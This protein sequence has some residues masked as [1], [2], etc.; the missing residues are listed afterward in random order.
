MGAKGKPR[1]QQTR[2][3][4]ILQPSVPHHQAP[5]RELGARSPAGHNSWRPRGPTDFDWMLLDAAD[6]AW[7]VVR[8]ETEAARPFLT[9]A[10][11]YD[12]L[13]Q[14]LDPEQ[15]LNLHDLLVRV[16]KQGRAVDL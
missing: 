4:T 9:P 10:E 7:E 14:R 3:R 12:R 15:V 11:Y 6:D 13:R 8:Q 2:G 1:R 16:G 5:P